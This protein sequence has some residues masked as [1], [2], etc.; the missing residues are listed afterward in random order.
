MP[1]TGASG[2]SDPPVPGNSHALYQPLAS[3]NPEAPAWKNRRLTPLL[4]PHKPCTFS[5]KNPIP[6]SPHCCSLSNS[7]RLQVSQVGTGNHILGVHGQ[8]IEPN[9]QRVN[10]RKRERDLLSDSTLHRTWEQA[11]SKPRLTS[12][13]GGILFLQGGYFVASFVRLLLHMY[14]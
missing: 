12:G 3:W 6:A 13:A 8:R 11:N 5:L 4:S 7:A 14:N 10:S 9:T 2:Q 1:A